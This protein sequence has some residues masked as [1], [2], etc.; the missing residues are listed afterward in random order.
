M[1]AITMLENK[2]VVLGKR[3]YRLSVERHVS[4]HTK[5]PYYMAYLSD[6]DSQYTS[7]KLFYDINSIKYGLMEWLEEAHSNNVGDETKFF[8]QLK[9]WNG[10]VPL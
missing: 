9:S 10:V 1:S 4:E 3:S 5:D 6:V 2:H 7:D 8:D